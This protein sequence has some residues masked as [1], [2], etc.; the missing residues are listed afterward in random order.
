MGC[1]NFLSFSILLMFCNLAAVG[2]TQWRPISY[3]LNHQNPCKNG[4]TCVDFGNSFQ[5]QCVLGGCTGLTCNYCPPPPNPTLPPRPEV[6]TP[7]PCR[8]DCYCTPSCKHSLGYYCK[9]EAGYLGKNC[10][11]PPPMLV[12]EADRIV[13]TVSELFVQEYDQGLQNSYI[14]V[15]PDNAAYGQSCQ[16]KS[17]S[18]GRYEVTIPLPF[19][20]CGTV[21]SVSRDPATAGSRMAYTNQMWFNRNLQSS[22]FDM[23]LP[24]IKFQCIYR[25]EYKITTSLV[26]IVPKPI[27]IEDEVYRRPS[28]SLCKV[29]ACPASC[30]SKF[31]VSDSAIYTVGE[32]IHVTM[33]L[34]AGSMVTGIDYLYLSCSSTPSTTDAV[35]IVRGGCGTRSGL[36]CEITQSAS[37][38]IVCVSFQTPRSLSCQKFYIHGRLND[39]N[40]GE[41]QTCQSDSS[42]RTC[43]T[44]RKRRSVEM[45]EEIS[46]GPIYILAGS[47]GIAHLKINGIDD[48]KAEVFDIIEPF[49]V[50][51]KTEPGTAGTFSDFEHPLLISMGLIASLLLFST[52]SV[53]VYH[54]R[55]RSRS[56]INELK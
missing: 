28:I 35:E 24:I 39:C 32:M 52:I 47:Q 25:W 51:Q 34:D 49:M 10:T 45:S 7:N 22:S 11:I 23:R 8:G 19:T 4:G 42:V 50:A 14:V 9:S 30:P 55:S 17:A 33:T 5:C 18:R 1:S 54:N 27:L 13:I 29:R 12:C 38:H 2:G 56:L 20:K 40:R 46:M 37:S 44:S 53:A 48:N 31:L 16:V 21:S 26:P 41:V 36:P 6:C 43:P 3:C 15:G